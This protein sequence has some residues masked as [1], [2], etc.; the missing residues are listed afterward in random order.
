MAASEFAERRYLPDRLDHQVRV[1]LFLAMAMGY[2]ILF[3]ADVYPLSVL[4]FLLPAAALGWWRFFDTRSPVFPE[5]VWTLV[6]LVLV[7]IPFALSLAQRL[8]FLDAL[9]FIFLLLPVIKLLTARSERDHLQLYALAFAQILYATII[10]LSLSFGILLALYMATT[11]WGLILLSFRSAVRGRPDESSLRRKVEKAVFRKSYIGFV[12]LLVPV[13][14]LLTFVLF[15]VLPRPGTSIA[16]FGFGLQK[17]HSGLGG[18]VDL[19]Q[20]GEIKLDRNAAFRAHVDGAPPAR[21]IYWRGPVLDYF[22][23]MGWSE[24]LTKTLEVQ[25]S[26]RSRIFQMSPWS[27]EQLTRSEIFLDGL[28]SK[29]LLHPDFI[30][31]AQVRANAIFL[32][33]GGG[34]TLSDDKRFLQNY[35]VWSYPESS[36]NLDDEIMNGF[37]QLP[38]NLDPRVTLLAGQITREA[39][40]P[41]DMA[42]RIE[43]HLKSDYVYSLNAGLMPSS[44]PLSNF[45]FRTR[46]GH[47]EFFA[48]AM[49]VM[50]RTLNIPSRLVTGYQEGEYNENED[51]FLIRQ[52]DAHAWV[53]AYLD[54]RWQRFDPTPAAGWETYARDL[55]TDIV[56]FFDSLSFRWQ[57]YVVTFSV[58]DQIR[59]LASLDQDIHTVRPEQA[60]QWLREHSMAFVILLLLILLPFAWSG[61]GFLRKR[62]RRLP[63]EE[64][65]RRAATRRFALLQ[66]RLT[67]AGLDPMPNETAAEM[68]ARAKRRFP[69]LSSLLARWLDLFETL[70]YGKEPPKESDLKTLDACEKEIE[71]SLR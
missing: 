50:L 20:V 16:N 31:R 38:P 9:N 23:G 39:T 5:F 41:S 58:R 18:Q 46:A 63:V 52:S 37:L 47:C 62:L 30:A 1:A 24:R 69:T 48:T 35:V 60:K 64:R 57:K 22:D 7:L 28:D 36:L 66:K 14:L 67:K 8:Y 12:A 33:A 3:M 43:Q 25:S 45:L 6:T 15:F 56:R 27:E 26:R 53:E 34:V 40:S 4:F 42:R 49:A 29:N 65:A 44:D 2:L 71:T 70:R 61:K 59:V 54:D 10:N 68:V 17:R 13:A 21:P 51:Y 32:H 19:G 55:F 11:M